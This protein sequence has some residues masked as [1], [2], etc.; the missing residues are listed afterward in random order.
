[1]PHDL[2]DYDAAVA[3][4]AGRRTGCDRRV[5]PAVAQA[6]KDRLGVRASTVARAHRFAAS[7]RSRRRSI[8]VQA[9]HA[10]GVLIA[11]STLGGSDWSPPA[12]NPELGYLFVDGNY[13]PQLYKLKPEE[14]EPP[15]QYWGGAVARAAGQGHTASTRRST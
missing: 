7:T 14:L 11:P 2:W 10:K 1:M 13:F 12:C 9:D 15:A 6:G 3:D 8:H 5:V 4:R